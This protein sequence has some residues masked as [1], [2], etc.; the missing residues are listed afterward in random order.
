[1]ELKTMTTDAFWGKENPEF[2][3]LIES[4]R[5][6]LNIILE[7]FLRECMDNQIECS[8]ADGMFLESACACLA[9]QRMYMSLE[10]KKK[11]KEKLK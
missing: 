10:R 7:K 5:N 1:M 11:E 2:G 3:E 6:D 8:S 4:L 9:R